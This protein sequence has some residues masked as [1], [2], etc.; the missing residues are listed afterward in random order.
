MVLSGDEIRIRL[1]ND[2][3]FRDGTWDDSCIKEASYALRIADDG[4]LID[5]RFYDPGDHYS[6]NYIEIEPGQIAILSTVEILN[7]PHNLVG[8]IGIRLN[9]ALRGLTGLMGIQVDPCYGQNRDD[10]RLFIRVANF[11]NQKISLSPGTE[12]FTFELHEVVGTIPVA[13][14][15]KKSTWKRLKE[16]LST[17]S[18]LSWSYV[19]QV[20]QTGQQNVKRVEEQLN[21]E[22]QK[23][24]D[25]L[26]PVVLFGIFLVAVTILG[27]CITLMLNFAQSS[28]AVEPGWVA[29][30]GWILALVT[31]SIATIATAAMGVLTIWRMWRHH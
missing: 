6:A 4:L 22:T 21:E 17:Q 13:T 20:Q 25:Y 19:T 15:D 24:R 16:E 14:T 3:I 5:G 26:Q 23:I 1:R 9:Y 7:M 2:E 28:D 31:I 12:V 10:E 11:G 8:K 29:N 27:V 30:W 18:K